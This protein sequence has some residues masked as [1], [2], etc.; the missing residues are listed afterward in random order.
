VVVVARRGLVGELS[1]LVL[2]DP[3]GPQ[4][5]GP[6]AQDRE[7]VAVL[8]LQRVD[9]SGGCIE[10]H[11]PCAYLRPSA[12]TW[13]AEAEGEDVGDVTVQSDGTDIFVVVDDV[14][15]AK[16]ARPGTP[17]AGTWISLEPGWRVTGGPD[18]IMIERDDD[19]RVH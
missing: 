14:R 13:S 17:Q 11:V 18:E 15:I 4:R 10:C 5:A 7:G 1:D 9:I 16:R 19:V 12:A 3:R 2:G 8:Q 6:G